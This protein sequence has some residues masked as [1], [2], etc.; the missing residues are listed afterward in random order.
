MA[1]ISQR[2]GKFLARVRITGLPSASAAFN[3]KRAAQAWAAHT[4][5]A[6]RRGIY[7]FNA[8]IIPPLREV[9][10]QYLKSRAF[11][12]KRGASIERYF[13]NDIAAARLASAPLD[14]VSLTTLTR[15]RDTWSN[16][17][18]ASTIARRFTMLRALY[19]YA[20]SDLHLPVENTPAKVRLQE[21]NDS[22]TRRPS[23]P[24][25]EAICAASGSSVLATIV[26]LAL[27]TAMRRG[28]ITGLRIENIDLATG[29]AL[30]PL[31]KN[32]H[33]RTVPL[34]PKAQATLQAAIG[35]RTHGQLFS[36]KPGSISQAF[37][38]AVTRARRAY[39]KDCTTKGQQADPTYLQN[40]RLHDARHDAIS[41]LIENGFSTIEASQVSGIE[42]LS[43]LQRYANLHPQHL[44]D[45]LAR[46]ERAA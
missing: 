13:F 38:R 43:I 32:G 23:K 33:T 41:R 46:M 4:E 35:E 7:Q 24:E 25:V 34:T 5:D 39:E 28:E 9:I 19:T 11:K 26:R 16:E 8:V 20:A 21:V 17:V 31:T 3:D 42:T 27:E 1:T 36:E 6:I 12:S 30:L 15:L 37:R 18:T 22:R 14:Q 40:L 29:T 2:N 45:K 44:V 10:G